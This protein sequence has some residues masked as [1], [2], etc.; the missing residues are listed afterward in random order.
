M[1]TAEL[2]YVAASCNRYSN[3]SD[4][5]FEDGLVAF[6]SGHFLALWNSAVS[7]SIQLNEPHNSS[8]DTRMLLP[9]EWSRHWPVTREKLQLLNLLNRI[10]PAPS[11]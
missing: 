3:V 6:G 8:Y 4:C 5:R 7:D 11:A 10:S 2:L 1:A 9:V